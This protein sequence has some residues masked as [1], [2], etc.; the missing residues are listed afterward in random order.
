MRA[1]RE[2]GFSI[3]AVAPLLPCSEKRPQQGRGEIELAD[4]DDDDVLASTLALAASAP[5]KAVG[6]AQHEKA[7]GN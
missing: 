2:T 6:M 3:L 5:R 1:S 4:S 7:A